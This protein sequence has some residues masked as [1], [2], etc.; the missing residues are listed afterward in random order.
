MWPSY[1]LTF[2]YVVQYSQMCDGGNQP[3]VYCVLSDS[4]NSITNGLLSVSVIGPLRGS[5]YLFQG[6]TQ[7]R[8]LGDLTTL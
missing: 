5:L 8:E 1:Q 7:H 4:C 2:L 6:S 3:V